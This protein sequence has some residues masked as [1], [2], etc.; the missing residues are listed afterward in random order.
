MERGWVAPPQ[1]PLSRMSGEKSAMC[2]EECHSPPGSRW[3]DKTTLSKDQ[4]GSLQCHQPSQQLHEEVITSSVEQT[5]PETR[6]NH[7]SWV[8]EEGFEFHQ[9]RSTC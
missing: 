7:S 9:I 6:N 4:A 2:D 3:T 8:A 5:D 1:G